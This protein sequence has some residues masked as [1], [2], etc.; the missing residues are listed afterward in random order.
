ME[1]TEQDGRQLE[2]LGFRSLPARGLRTWRTPVTNEILHG[3][4]SRVMTNH[5]SFEASDRGCVPGDTHS[6][7]GNCVRNGV[8][9]PHG[10]WRFK[11][12]LYQVF[13]TRRKGGAIDPV[14]HNKS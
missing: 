3:V 4:I 7:R 10:L 2:Q 12:W 9:D 6:E 5:I 13:Q 11:C 1:K 14:T 8:A